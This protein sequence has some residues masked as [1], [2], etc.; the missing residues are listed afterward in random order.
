MR[1]PRILIRRQKHL[2]HTFTYKNIR[3]NLLIDIP[4]RNHIVV[5]QR[6]MP[7][8]DKHVLRSKFE[9]SSRESLQIVEAVNVYGLLPG[10][11]EQEVCFG[12]VGG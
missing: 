9:N 8:L 12:D 4:F 5:I 11:L 10:C 3:H 6:H 7:A 1:I 2:L